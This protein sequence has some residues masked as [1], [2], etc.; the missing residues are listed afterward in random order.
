MATRIDYDKSIKTDTLKWRRDLEGNFELLHNYFWWTFI[1]VLLVIFPIKFSIDEIKR[2]TFFELSTVFYFLFISFGLIGLYGV[3]IIFRLRRVT[4]LDSETNRIIITRLLKRDFE[5]INVN[6]T[7][8]KILTVKKPL[9]L[10]SF[11]QRV[12]VLFDGNDI[13]INILTIA[14][15]DVLSI[16]H[17][18]SNDDKVKSIIREFK[19]EIKKNNPQQN[20]SAMVP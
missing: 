16:F 14:N 3:F 18:M 9:G 1:T 7:G 17:S 8:T 4:G 20:V 15:H 12:T 2:G 11:G 6:A 13:L 5:R 10:L 19:E